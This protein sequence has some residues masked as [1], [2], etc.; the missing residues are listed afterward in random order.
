M[1]IC[2]LLRVIIN[3]WLYRPQTP[4]KWWFIDNA[5]SFISFFRIISIIKSTI[6][7]LFRFCFKNTMLCNNYDTAKFD[8]SILSTSSS[9]SSSTPNQI[10]T[11]A[12]NYP[13]RTKFESTGINSTVCNNFTWTES[14]DHFDYSQDFCDNCKN[15][16][17]SHCKHS[18]RFFVFKKESNHGIFTEGSLKSVL[19]Y[20]W[21]FKYNFFE[22]RFF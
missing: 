13:N 16:W 9:V 14:P 11:T 7:Y 3:V 8:T 6:F 10:Q 18:W 4:L 22:S 2:L 12:L 20:N 21:Q 15:S 5:I 17:L 19:L 1:L